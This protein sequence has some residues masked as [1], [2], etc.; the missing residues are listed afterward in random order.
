MYDFSGKVAFI[1]GIKSLKDEEIKKGI[2]PG[3]G[4]ALLKGLSDAGAHVIATYHSREPTPEFMSKYHGNVEYLSFDAANHADYQ[5]LQLRIHEKTEHIDFLIHTI[6]KIDGMNRQKFVEIGRR[7]KDNEQKVRQGLLP[8]PNVLR[9]EDFSEDEIQR[10]IDISAGSYV[11]LVY[12]LRKFMPNGSAVVTYSLPNH[13]LIPNYGIASAAKSVLEKEATDFK[14][15]DGNNR[16]YFV[17]RPD[18]FL[19]LSSSV[20]PY[21]HEYLQLMRENSPDNNIVTSDDVAKFTMSILEK[22]A[23][24]KSQC[25]I[26]MGEYMQFTTPTEF[27]Q[28]LFASLK[29]KIEQKQTVE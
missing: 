6:M 18:A 29:S 11:K 5:D 13:D 4:E 9:L 26:N 25:I 23:E 20:F 27:E 2:Q 21:I 7:M 16:R 8:D 3:L 17:I 1:A 28:M 10:T 19:T 14:A 15:T 24:M 22:G 12:S